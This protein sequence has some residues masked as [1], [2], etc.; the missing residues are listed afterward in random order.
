MRNG[1]M[2]RADII[3]VLNSPLHERRCAIAQMV[4]KPNCPILARASRCSARGRRYIHRYLGISEQPRLLV[5]KW[6]QIPPREVSRLLD[7]QLF[8]LCKHSKLQSRDTYSHV[9]LAFSWPW[10]SV[11]IRVC[12]GRPCKTERPQHLRQHDLHKCVGKSLSSGPAL[13]L[14]R[15]LASVPSHSTFVISQSH[16]YNPQYGQRP[17]QS[18]FRALRFRNYSKQRHPSISCRRGMCLLEVA[19]FWASCC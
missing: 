2:Q 6:M 9:N 17:R 7:A 15:V 12:A 19:S 3:R 1:R 18:L 16:T 14:R 11:F 4:I 5:V 13:R 10:L 8:A